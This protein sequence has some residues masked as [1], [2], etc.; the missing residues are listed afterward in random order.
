MLSIRH[1]FHLANQTRWERSQTFARNSVKVLLLTSISSIDYCN[2]LKLKQSVVFRQPQSAFERVLPTERHH[3]QVVRVRGSRAGRCPWKVRIWG[4]GCAALQHKCTNTIPF[5]ICIICSTRKHGQKGWQI[6][7]QTDFKLADNLE[8]NISSSSKSKNTLFDDESGKSINL[9][10]FHICMKQAG[11]GPSRRHIQG[12][13]IAKGLQNFQV[14]VNWDYFYEKKIWKKS[15]NA[16]KKLKGR[17]L[18]DFSTSIL[19]QNSKKNE[20]GPFVVKKVFLK[21]VA[22]CRKNGPF[23]LVRYCMLRRKPFWFSSLGQQVHFGVFW[24]ICRT[25]GRTI[26]VSSGG[27]KKTL[28]KS[29]D[30]SRLFSKEKRRLKMLEQITVWWNVLFKNYIIFGDFSKFWIGFFQV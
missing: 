22:Q 20:G 10:F 17:S 14:L 27:L 28:T 26:L 23:G 4:T 13:K 3:R 7:F 2:P 5:P 8:M 30:Y 15:H 18:W 19:L 24:K 29:H 1:N 16:E 25:F 9:F 12:S 11:N 21:K 6:N